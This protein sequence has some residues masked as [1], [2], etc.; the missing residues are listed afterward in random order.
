[1]FTN[2]A[3][4]GI[5]VANNDGIVFGVNND[6]IEE[7]AGTV[8]STASEIVVC[9]GISSSFFS[10]FSSPKSIISKKCLGIKD[11]HLHS[12]SFSL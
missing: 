3:G 6:G 10:F 9:S 12:L 1:M 11:F 5:D 2:A 4:V 7:L 8:V